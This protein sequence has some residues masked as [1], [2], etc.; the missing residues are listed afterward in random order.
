M[1]SLEK[2]YAASMVRQYTMMITPAA[3]MALFRKN[4]GTTP[5][6]QTTL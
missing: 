6:S 3:M 5:V 2:P 1:C 4:S